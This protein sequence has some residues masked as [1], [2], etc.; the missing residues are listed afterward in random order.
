V[1]RGGQVED[2]KAVRELEI[3]VRDQAGSHSLGRQT[4]TMYGIRDYKGI[5]KI[6]NK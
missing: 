6:Q 2:R 5:Q 1:C 4:E 3:R